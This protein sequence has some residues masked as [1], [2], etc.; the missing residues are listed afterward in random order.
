M[1]SEGGVITVDE[2]TRECASCGEKMTDGTVQCPACGSNELRPTE[3][4]VDP[5][6]RPSEMVA[7]EAW[8]VPTKR[9]KWWRVAIGPVLVA[10]ALAGIGAYRNRPLPPVPATVTSVGDVCN[11]FYVRT[12]RVLN[13]HL[14]DRHAKAQFKGLAAAAGTYDAT[15]TAALAGLT[16]GKSKN[17][18]ANNT[19]TVYERCVALG[20]PPTPDQAASIRAGALANQ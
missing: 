6:W 7:P 10:V 1:R 14:D 18:V 15:I 16:A 17:D 5:L 12:I 9:R 11:E 4:R 2:F 20:F 19:I 13:G 3:Q 8:P